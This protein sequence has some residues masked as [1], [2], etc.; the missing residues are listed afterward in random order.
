MIMKNLIRITDNYDEAE[1]IC[2]DV[3]E[4][5]FGRI[6]LKNDDY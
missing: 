6:Y 2:K 5:R 3:L 1:N 4:S